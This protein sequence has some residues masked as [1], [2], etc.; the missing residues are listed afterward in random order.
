MKRTIDEEEER[1]LLQS[2]LE[3]DWDDKDIKIYQLLRNNGRMTDTEIAEK[4]DMSITTARRRRTKLEE[5]GYIYLMALLVLQAVGVAYA[6]TIVKINPKASLQELNKFIAEA[7][8]NPRIYEVTQY[9]GKRALL[10]R[11]YEKNMERVSKHINEFLLG[12]R[13]VQDYEIYPAVS[14]PKAWNSITE[15]YYEEKFNKYRDEEKG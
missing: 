11:F 9:I 4:L 2:I 15:K 12:N 3:D 13:L 1:K 10:F 7:V 14:S 8:A 5:E 6:D